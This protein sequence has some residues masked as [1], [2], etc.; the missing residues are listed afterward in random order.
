M[1][2]GNKAIKLKKFKRKRDLNSYT[3]PARSEM[4][5]DL[6]DSLPETV[7]EIDL[8]GKLTFVNR[9][10]YKTFG[11][12]EED[13]KQGLNVLQMLVP[14]EHNRALQNIFMVFHGENLNGL[15]YTAR[16]KD[17][18]IFPIAVYPTPI[19]K[20]DRVIGMRGIIIDITRRSK[21]CIPENQMVM[22]PFLYF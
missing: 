10:A 15:E 21:T 8:E 7:F 11:Y 20:E 18:R 14:E 17:G 2:F 3:A 9:T 13:F 22:K 1:K 19:I 16:R 12:T 6:V 5:Y 4:F